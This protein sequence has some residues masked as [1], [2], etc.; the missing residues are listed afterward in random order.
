MFTQYDFA[1]C[2]QINVGICKVKVFDIYFI[3]KN[4][5]FSHLFIYF[6]YTSKYSNQSAILLILSFWVQVLFS[7]MILIELSEWITMVFSFKNMRDFSNKN[8]PIFVEVAVQLF[9]STPL[10]C[11]VILIKFIWYFDWYLILR[12]GGLWIWT[13]FLQKISITMLSLHHYD[14]TCWHSKKS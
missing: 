3:H 8:P 6:Y 14:L 10:I 5:Y 7:W 1:A 2:H 11:L 13:W 12:I 9:K 4:S